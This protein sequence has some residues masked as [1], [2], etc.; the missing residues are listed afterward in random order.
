MWSFYSRLSGRKPVAFALVLAALASPIAARTLAGL[1]PDGVVSGPARVIDG[2]TI[3]IAGTRI[4]LEGIDAPE[5]GQTC[6]TAAG[7][8]WD[9]GNAAT[10]AIVALTRER[11]VD[12][13]SRG[14][15]TYGRMLGI[16]FAGGRDINAEM[17]RTGY[18]WAFVRYSQHYVAE[19]AT[20][21]AAKL[22]VWQG[23]ST[24]AWEYRAQKWAA[25]STQ[26]ATPPGCAIKGNVSHAGM[27]Y[28]MP[29]SPWYGKVVMRAGKGTRWFCS[30]ADALAAGWRPAMMR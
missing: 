24:P 22:G 21:R 19:E 30:E 16:C 23:P 15:D 1:P 2:D 7:E 20:A 29:W 4:R 26:P 25:A 18:A 3:D 11:Q 9:C 14:L 28:H 17:V 8:T 5:T 27:I 12:C 10:R 6:Q 13:H